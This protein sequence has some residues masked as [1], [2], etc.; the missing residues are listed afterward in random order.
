MCVATG[1]AGGTSSP[2]S[3]Y[4]RRMSH[5]CAR[6]D[7]EVVESNMIDVGTRVENSQALGLEVIQ[8]FQVTRAVLG[9]EVFSYPMLLLLS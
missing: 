6:T 3:G 9:V 1:G 4:K 8:S 7:S 2:P 5:D